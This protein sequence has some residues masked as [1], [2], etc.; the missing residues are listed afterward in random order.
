MKII[1]NLFI[2]LLLVAGFQACDD[3]EELLDQTFT[4]NIDENIPFDLSLAGKSIYIDCTPKA[5]SG[6]K[7]LSIDNNDTHEYLNKIKSVEIKSLTY[8]IMNFNGPDA[9]SV[10]ASLYFDNELMATENI[11]LKTAAAN[12]TVYEVTNTE[13]LNRVANN[14]RSRHTI[15]ARY[16][17]SANQWCNNLTFRIQIR[18]QVKV[19]ANPL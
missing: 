3:A 9:S 15:T 17:G 8:K 2:L 16:E 11:M 14:L 7:T 13:L 5:F 18:M 12:G 6:T 4:V 19:I 1:F 10:A